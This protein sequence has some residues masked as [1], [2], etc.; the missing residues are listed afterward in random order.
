MQVDIHII[1]NIK[2]FILITNHLTILFF[3]ILIILHH[4]YLLFIINF[5]AISLND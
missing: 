3:T 1:Y 5:I 4:Y 2:I